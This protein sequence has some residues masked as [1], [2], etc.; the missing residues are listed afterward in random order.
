MERRGRR[1]RS[2]DVPRRPF[3]RGDSSSARTY[4]SIN[5][6]KALYPETPSV[7]RPRSSRR[8]MTGNLRQAMKQGSM[9]GRRVPERSIQPWS[10][11]DDETLLR[12]LAVGERRLDIASA[13]GRSRSSISSRRIALAR[14]GRCPLRDPH[15]RTTYRGAPWSSDDCEA[16]RRML[17]DGQD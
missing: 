3:Q 9:N 6:G 11:D 4:G 14:E 1:H 2:P 15:S 17:S 12:M 13:L 8:T 16:L 10:D 7:T 5:L